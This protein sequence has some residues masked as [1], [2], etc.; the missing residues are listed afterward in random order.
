MSEMTEKKVYMGVQVGPL[1]DIQAY[2]EPFGSLENSYQTFEFYGGMQFKMWD[3]FDDNDHS[4]SLTSDVGLA[5]TAGDFGTLGSTRDQVS[6]NVGLQQE[7]FDLCY[8]ETKLGFSFN[9]NNFNF[10]RGSAPESENSLNTR[11]QFLAGIE[12]NASDNGGIGIGILGGYFFEWSLAGLGYE[13]QGLL[14]GLRLSFRAENADNFNEWEAEKKKRIEAEGK[15]VKLKQDLEFVE[16]RLG[17]WSSDFV[18]IL[19]MLEKANSG[20]PGVFYSD[21]FR[22]PAGQEAIPTTAIKDV[23]DIVRHENE[24]LHAMAQ[25]LVDNPRANLKIHGFSA[26]AADDSSANAKSLRLARNVQDYLVHTEGIKR[27]RIMIEGDF[28]EK[29]ASGSSVHGQ[30]VDESSTEPAVRSCTRTDCVAFEYLKL[31]PREDNGIDVEV[32]PL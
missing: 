4:G 21:I 7:F 11:L 29:G 15:V 23:G 19:E 31:S 2:D 9:L 25:W 26:E 17:N 10:G 28:D 6:L 24:A 16:K 8:L 14:F 20:N 30:R 32:R 1:D 12:G 27:E 13:N 3:L 18:R 22:F 5:L